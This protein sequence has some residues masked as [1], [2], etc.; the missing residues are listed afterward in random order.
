MRNRFLIASALIVLLLTACTTSQPLTQPTVTNSNNSIK[1]ATS[2]AAVI[3]SVWQPP[4][5]RWQERIT[6][7][8]FSIKVSPQN[9][10]VQHEKFSGYHTG[11]D[12]ETFT[13]EADTVVTIKTICAGKIIFKQRVSGYGGVFIQS[14]QYNGQPITVMYGHLVLSSIKLKIGSDIKAGTIIGNL[15][16]GYSYDTDGERKH[17]HLGIHLGSKVE[18]KGYV[19]TEAELSGWLDAQ[20]ILGLK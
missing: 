9:S 2:T 7:K 5:D 18:L 17:L 10:P 12:F 15:G 8:P 13:D 11:V 6:K 14:C 1:S 4:L 3:E 16:Q 20:K 19:Q